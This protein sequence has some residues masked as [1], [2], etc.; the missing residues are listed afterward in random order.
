M[1]TYLNDLLGYK[2][3]KTRHLFRWKVVEAYRAERVQASELE[4]T[5]GIPMR[6]LRRLNRNYFRLRLLPLLQPK[7]RR[8]TM[9]RDADYVKTLERKLADME[10]EN[11]FLRLQ[12]EAYQTVI[13]IA[14]EQFNI[15]IVKKPGARRPKN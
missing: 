11:Q 9:K 14:E 5:L 1:N 6:E 12:A 4:E 13:Q 10:K 15:P 2:K 3:K 8:K 7:N